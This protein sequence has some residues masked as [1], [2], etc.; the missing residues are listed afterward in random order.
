MFVV[1]VSAAAPACAQTFAGVR[2]PASGFYGGIALRDD[3]A[4]SGGINFGHLVSTWGR[5]APPVTDD[6]A[7]RRSLLFG[8][9]RFSNDVSLEG[10]FSTT[11][12]RQLWPLDAG[13]PRGVG[14][15]L[16]TARG[17]GEH[18]W[19]ADVYTAWSFLSSF[20]LYG[21]LGYA[22]RDGLPSYAVAALSPGDARPLRD[23]VNYGVG[24]RYDVTRA[25]GLRLEYARF[26]RF[27]GETVTGPLPDSD[28]VQFGV[29]FRF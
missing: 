20:S 13:T 3:G 16:A 15:S 10:S 22:Q 23:G 14:L 26:P 19:N 6:A 29:Q 24:V 2:G 21:R 5:Y 11:D 12:R 27:A 4:D 25:L 9:Y 8:G 7:S 17:L 1:A 28:Q 18:S